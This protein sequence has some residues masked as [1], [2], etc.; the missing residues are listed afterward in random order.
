MVITQTRR[1]RLENRATSL[2]RR[3]RVNESFKVFSLLGQ[4]AE[5]ARRLRFEGD[6]S[7]RSGDTDHAVAAFVVASFLALPNSIRSKRKRRA[8]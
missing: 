8:R 3:G 1:T 6:E 5:Y 7:L 2:L 4:A